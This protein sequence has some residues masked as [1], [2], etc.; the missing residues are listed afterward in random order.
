MKGKEIELTMSEFQ[1]LKEIVDMMKGIGTQSTVLYDLHVTGWH[2]EGSAHYNRNDHDAK[3]TF[4]LT[5]EV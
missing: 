3:I 5:T 4:N 2:G 1:V